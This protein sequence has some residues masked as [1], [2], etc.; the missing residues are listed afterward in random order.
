VAAIRPEIADGFSIAV[1]HG[2]CDVEDLRGSGIAFWA[3]GGR[4]E[5]LTLANAPGMAQ[6]SGSPQGRTPDEPGPHGCVLVDVD[7]SGTPHTQF[8]ATDVVRWIHEKIELGDD[9]NQAELMRV[10]RERSS[11][12]LEESGDRQVLVLWSILDN[13]QL[14]D[15]RSDR[16]AAEL[17]QQDLATQLLKQLRASF[18][19]QVPGVWSVSL[20]ADPPA[21]LPAGWYEEDTILGDL[22]RFVKHFQQE[23]D[24]PL[25]LA[26]W[27]DGQAIDPTLEQALRVD[28]PLERDYLLRRVA[29]LGVDLL[30]G[31]RVLSEDEHANFAWLDMD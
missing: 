8:I 9:T 27:L 20:E 14:A 13:D 19:S 17:R 22:L 23:P 6:Y 3:L 25:D 16:L 29:V 18:G 21:V 10:L 11:R 7:S 24:E 28:D 5:R 31:D 1:A 2:S 26:L 4:H 30:R 15:T 12:L